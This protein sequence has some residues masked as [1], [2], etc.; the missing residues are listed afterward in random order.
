MTKR[1]LVD[2]NSEKENKRSFSHFMRIKQIIRKYPLMV[3][4]SALLSLSIVLGNHICVENPYEGTIKENTIVPYSITDLLLFVLLLVLLTMVFSLVTEFLLLKS[5]IRVKEMRPVFRQR[6]LWIG[7]GFLFV[8]WFPYLLHFYPGFI[9]SDSIASLNEALG[10]RPLSNRNPVFFTLFLR[11]CLLLGKAFSSHDITRGCLTYSV[12]QMLLL[13]FTIAYL[14]VWLSIR[15]TIKK[16]VGLSLIAIA[17]FCPYIAQDSI[18]MWK[19]PLFSAFVV[20]LTLMLVDFSFYPELLNRT[21]WKFCFC[22]LVCLTLVSRNNG[23][24]AV[25]ALAIALLICLLK[26]HSDTM[27]NIGRKLF[28]RVVFITTLWLVIT[29]HLFQTFGIG[30]TPKEESV[31]MMFNQMARVAALNGKMSEEDEDYLDSILST[32]QYAQYYHPCTVDSLKWNENVDLM[33]LYSLRFYKTYASLLIKNPRIFFEAWELESYGFWTV[34]K[35]EINLQTDNIS[36]GV[37]VNYRGISD[38]EIGDYTLTLKPVQQ[39]D[40]TGIALPTDSWSIP[41]G[42]LNWFFLFVLFVLFYKHE[43]GLIL[44]LIPI[45]GIIMGIIVGTPIWYLPRYELSTQIITPLLVLLCLTKPE[46]I[47]YT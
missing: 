11:V 10:I 34:N 24:T 35:T 9:F 39:R 33:P 12:I 15:F 26:K 44:A 28:P 4:Y 27:N 41:L 14:I 20:L 2:Q 5:S 38:N 37:P 36:F 3:W 6:M 30:G 29:G 31:G 13:A 22:C 1:V 47:T 8:A 42:I 40:E 7:W 18:A 19:D 21:G 32:D 25:L 45:A 43:N 16:Y 46:R 23:V 17:A